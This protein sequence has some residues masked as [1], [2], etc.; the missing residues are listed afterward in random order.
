MKKIFTCCM[1]AMMIA[2]VACSKSEPTVTDSTTFAPL[3]LSLTILPA[4]K[5]FS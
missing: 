5:I 2:I 1:L 3:R 4:D